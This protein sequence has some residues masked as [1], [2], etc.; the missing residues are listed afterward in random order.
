MEHFPK[1]GDFAEEETPLDGKK[2]K[3]DEILNIEILVIGF[4]IGESKFKDKNYLT[5][6]FENGNEKYIVFTGSEVLINQIQKYKENIPFY[7]VIKKVN[8][9][10]TMT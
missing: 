10:Y 7:T 6:Q 4:R 8:K 1:F 3:V 2:R 5:L 9:Y